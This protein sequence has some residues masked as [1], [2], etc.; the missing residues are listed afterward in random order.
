MSAIADFFRYQE[1]TR[2]RAFCKKAK[3]GICKSR[4]F[5][6]EKLIYLVSMFSDIYWKFCDP[7]AIF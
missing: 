6:N 3:K 5:I 2:N 1:S 4:E 7:F